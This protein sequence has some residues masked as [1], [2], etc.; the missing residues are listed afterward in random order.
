MEIETINLPKSERFLGLSGCGPSDMPVG[1]FPPNAWGLHDMHGNVLEWRRDWYSDYAAGAQ[2]GPT[3]PADGKL[4][5]LR[6]GSWESSADLCRSAFRSR[7][8]R[9]SQRRRVPPRLS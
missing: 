2:K 6:G 7:V 9:E 1:G 8:A 4:R 5:V 3:G